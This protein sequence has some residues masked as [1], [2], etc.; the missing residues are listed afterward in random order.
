MIVKTKLVYYC[1]HCKK[2]YLSKHHCE[3]H[4]KRCTHNRQRTCGFCG[5][6]DRFMEVL[7]KWEE[8]ARRFLGDS[9]PPWGIFEPDKWEKMRKAL[10]WRLINDDVEGCPGC[11]LSILNITKI[12]HAALEND[13]PFDF[14]AE[15]KRW[16]DN[17][18]IRY[19]AFPEEND[20]GMW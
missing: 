5:V 10:S 4:E 15:K 1:E 16:W 11:T 17:K 12:N 7:G 2:R 9:P 13:D 6:D 3:K 18:N 8:K 20:V 14:A 19:E